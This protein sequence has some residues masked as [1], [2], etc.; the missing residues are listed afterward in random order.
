[1]TLP[2]GGG[3]SYRQATDACELNCCGMVRGTSFSRLNLVISFLYNAYTVTTLCGCSV[4][5]LFIS[6][7]VYESCTDA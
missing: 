4:M 3:R 2:P 5:S 7:L 1:M 6:P